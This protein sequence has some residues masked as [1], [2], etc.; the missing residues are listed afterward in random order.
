MTGLRYAHIRLKMRIA[1]L[2]RLDNRL[3][4]GVGSQKISLR[5]YLNNGNNAGKNPA[6]YP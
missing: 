6:L 1:A 4:M 3:A 2:E 5:H